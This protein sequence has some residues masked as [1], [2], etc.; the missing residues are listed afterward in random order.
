M[1][2]GAQ[3][4][5]DGRCAFRASRKSCRIMTA[6]TWST[7]LRCAV[8]AWPASYRRRWASLVVRR[9]SHRCTGSFVSSASCWAK[10][11]VFSDCLLCSPERWSGLPTTISRQ[12]DRRASLARER[13]SSRGFLRVRVR[14]GWAVSPNSSETATPIRRLPT[15]SPKRRGTEPCS[16]SRIL[17]NPDHACGQKD[18]H[19]TIR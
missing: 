12:P 18:S 10:V 3:E 14:T 16:M 17:S 9:S 2:F 15:S 11:C 4:L 7:I 6:A 1:R 5:Q 13:R 19:H 8:R